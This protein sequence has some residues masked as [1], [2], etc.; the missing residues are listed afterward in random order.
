MAGSCG[1]LE[2]NCNNGVLGMN[3]KALVRAVS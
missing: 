3:V 2:A 1:I